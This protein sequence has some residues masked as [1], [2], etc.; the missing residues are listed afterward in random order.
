MSERDLVMAEVVERLR[1]GR[2]AL[3]QWLANDML[4]PARK[5]PIRIRRKAPVSEP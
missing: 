5:D 2:S 1:V 4:R 3:D